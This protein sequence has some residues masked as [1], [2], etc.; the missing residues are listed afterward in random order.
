MGPACS[1]GTDS[2]AS[3]LA[4]SNA[5]AQF[6]KELR[7]PPPAWHTAPA[8]TPPLTP[9]RVVSGGLEARG[10]ARS[11]VPKVSAV[12]GWM[13]LWTPVLCGGGTLSP[14]SHLLALRPVASAAT[15]RDSREASNVAGGAPTNFVGMPGGI[16]L[17]LPGLAPRRWYRTAIRKAAA[18]LLSDRRTQESAAQPSQTAATAM[19]EHSEARL[20]LA[21]RRPEEVAARP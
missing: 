12:A 8:P 1:S 11:A 17:E 5:C 20:G 2:H 16:G 10:A 3:G 7:E 15:A 13:N 19:A 9:T 21:V 4:R 18:A 6:A 14:L